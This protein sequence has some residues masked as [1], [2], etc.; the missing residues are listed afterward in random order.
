MLNVALSFLDIKINELYF[1]SNLE[2]YSVLELKLHPSIE[3]E[4][5][6]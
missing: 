5:Y 3:W 4:E 6:F 1:Y 2:F